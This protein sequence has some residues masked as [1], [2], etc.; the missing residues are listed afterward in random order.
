MLFLL[1]VL[2]LITSPV[3]CSSSESDSDSS[4]SSGAS[5]SNETQIKIAFAL[6]KAPP[7]S[8]NDTA[9]PSGDNPHDNHDPHDPDNS[10][11]DG[12]SVHHSFHDDRGPW[13]QRIKREEYWQ[14]FALM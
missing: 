10:D 2:C 6:A 14:A 7:L 3:T 11:H 8:S 12:N 4:D 13:R 9:V 1:M 5:D